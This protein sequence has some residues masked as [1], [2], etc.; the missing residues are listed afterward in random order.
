M[1]LE[2]TVGGAVVELGAVAVVVEVVVAVEVAVVLGA[3]VEVAEHPTPTA[4]AARL[5]ATTE[6]TL[7]TP[8]AST[9]RV[10]H[11]LRHAGPAASSRRG[12]P[13]TM[14]ARGVR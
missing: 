4:P 6:T 13:G 3:G 7:T 14:R 5:A 8:R 2:V 11:S 10:W 12:P 9:A 1:V